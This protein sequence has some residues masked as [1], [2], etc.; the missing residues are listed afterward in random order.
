MIVLVVA[1]D[2]RRRVRERVARSRVHRV[3][4]RPGVRLPDELAFGGA[5]ALHGRL[6]LPGDKSISHRALLFAALATGRSS[7]TNLAT[8]DDVRAM[9]A[10]SSRSVSEI[11]D[12]GR[13]GDGERQR[14]R[15]DG[16]SRKACSTAATAAPRC[17]C[18]P[19][20]LA[21]RPFLSVLTRRRVARTA[22]D[23]PRDRAAARDGRARRR[24]RR[25]RS[26]RRSSIR[27]GGAARACATS[28]RSRARR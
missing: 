16:A 17:A 15:R 27:G 3:A 19:G 10:R 1:A 9:R 22:A 20:A 18:L 25:R 26:T 21:G 6:R 11:R 24:P 5:R 28:W 12:D 13:R 7:L 23:A 2:R 8:G 4:D 14:S